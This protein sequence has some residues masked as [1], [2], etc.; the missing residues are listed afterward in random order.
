MTT[1]VIGFCGW[2]SAKAADVIPK[3]TARPAPS[4]RPCTSSLRLKIFIVFLLV[5]ALRS[6]SNR[7]VIPALIGGDSA[8]E[9]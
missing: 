4:A 5:G 3:E 7:A 1:N 2:N 8:A 6:A 9:R